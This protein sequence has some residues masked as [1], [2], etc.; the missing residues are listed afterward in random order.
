MM[1]GGCL[2]GIG[3]VAASFCNS[4]EALYL[5]VGVL[6]G[7]F[8]FLYCFLFWLGLQS[9]VLTFTVHVFF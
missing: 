1:A 3:F 6:G 4:V 7:K 9:N 2:S 8:Y 5:C